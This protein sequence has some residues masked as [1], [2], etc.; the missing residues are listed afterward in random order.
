MLDG[1]RAAARGLHSASRLDRFPGEWLWGRKEKRQGA[2]RNPRRGP[3]GRG[4]VRGRVRRVRSTRGISRPTGPPL[5]SPARRN[6]ARNASSGLTNDCRGPRRGP[7]MP[8]LTLRTLLAYI[9]DTLE[10]DQARAL[11][12]KVAESAEAKQ[13]IERIKKVTRRRRL[14]A[15]VPDGTE[16]DIS[17]PNTVAEYLSD[18]LDP[19]QLKPFESACLESD[20]HLAE[21]A[22]CPQILLLVMTDPGRVPPSANQ[23]MY[24]LVEPPASDP[25]RRPGKG[26]PVAGATPPATEHAEDDHD[27]A[28][29]LGM[30]RYTAS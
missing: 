10:P 16:D 28:L 8:R 5:F 2:D 14:H 6:L 11:G 19:D 30:K 26:M 20:V 17:D 23:R 1:F 4:G 29:L 25:R 22:A 24:K 18:N 3:G 15:P 9:D 7:H 21:V 13:L 12:R 27:A